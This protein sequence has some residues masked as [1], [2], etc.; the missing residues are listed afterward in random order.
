MNDDVA[1]EGRL[2]MVEWNRGGETW[3]IERRYGS[4]RLKKST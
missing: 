3:S 4:V 1:L 2:E